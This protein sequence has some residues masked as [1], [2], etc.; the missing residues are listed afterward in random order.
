[1]EF[2]GRSWSADLL[3][4]NFLDFRAGALYPLVVEA[5]LLTTVP[6][7]SGQ[8]TVCVCFAQAIFESFARLIE[9]R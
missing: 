3:V 9:W 6:H 4:E 8:A 2:G 1:M 7:T 5:V